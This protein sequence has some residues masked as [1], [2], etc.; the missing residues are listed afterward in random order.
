MVLTIGATQPQHTDYDLFLLHHFCSSTAQGFESAGT[1]G[2]YSMQVVQLGTEHPYLMHA[3]LALSACHLQHIGIEAPQYRLPESLHCHFAS[4]GLRSAVAV[5]EG[6]KQSHAVLSTAML[7]NTLTFCVADY[8]DEP[9]LSPQ[10]SRGPSWDWLRIQTGLTSLLSKTAPYHG[11]SIWRVVFRASNTFKITEPP[12]NNLDDDLRVFCGVNEQS[13]SENN[14]YLDV[15]ELLGPLVT[16]TPTSEYLLS[17][18]RPVGGMSSTF[19]TLLEQQ[20]IRALL[21]F[22]HWLALMCSIDHWWCVVRTSRECWKI[23]ELLSRRLDSRD[24]HLL[25]I[26]ARACGYLL[27]D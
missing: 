7:L 2:I 20:D 27:S 15:L 25:N 14:P 23:C 10:N 26:P 22:A 6:Q 8:R 1:T 21:L 12:V 16:R 13:T 19:V 4:R 24:T 18:L 9:R 11:E 5:I 17:Y 3:I